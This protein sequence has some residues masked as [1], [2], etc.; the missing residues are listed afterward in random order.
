MRDKRG[1]RG[2]SRVVGWRV[3]EI[4]LEKVVEL[5]INLKGNTER[6]DVCRKCDEISTEEQRETEKACLRE[7]WRVR[8]RARCSDED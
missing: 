6:G 8:E 1:M 5:K 7:V 3:T 2:E 4:N